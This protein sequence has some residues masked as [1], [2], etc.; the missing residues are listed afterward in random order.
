MYFLP[1]TMTLA[2]VQTQTPKKP[3]QPPPVS[4]HTPTP[5]NA[6][7]SSNSNVVWVT[8]SRF[9]H[10]VLAKLRRGVISNFVSGFPRGVA[11]PLIDEV[12]EIPN[13]DVPPVLALPL[14]PPGS[15]DAYAYSSNGLSSPPLTTAFSATSYRVAA[16]SQLVA[17]KASAFRSISLA[18]I[19][20]ATIQSK[21]CMAAVSPLIHQLKMYDC[22]LAAQE[23]RTYMRPFRNPA[24]LCLV[25]GDDLC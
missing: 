16:A 21:V 9:F 25:V 3:K 12:S 18:T 19:F 23:R 13:M 4:S 20:H 10:F 5:P 14:P 17:D 7:T 22:H 6:S 2:K 24:R 8:L 11:L 1:P 15:H